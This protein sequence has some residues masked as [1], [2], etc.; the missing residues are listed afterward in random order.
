[1]TIRASVPKQSRR[2]GDGCRY[3]NSTLTGSVASG[4]KFS[5][6]STV[7]KAYKGYEHLI[8]DHVP[9]RRLDNLV[10]YKLSSDL[11]QMHSTCSSQREKR[12]ISVYCSSIPFVVKDQN[13]RFDSRKIRDHSIT[14]ALPEPVRNTRMAS[15]RLRDRSR[16]SRPPF[17]AMATQATV[18]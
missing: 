1:M 12:C 8:E 6:C 4:A 11:W 18:P 15:P 17:K 10:A 5:L 14:A 2:V 3:K 7:G 9:C 16:F 13:Q